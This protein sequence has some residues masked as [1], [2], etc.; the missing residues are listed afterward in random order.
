MPVLDGLAFLYKK[1]WVNC[2]QIDYNSQVNRSHQLGHSPGGYAPRGVFFLATIVLWG[3]KVSNG[4]VRI[5]QINRSTAAAISPMIIPKLINVSGQIRRPRI[6][7]MIRAPSWL[8]CDSPIIHHSQYSTRLVSSFERII[9]IFSKSSILI[10]FSASPPSNHPQHRNWLNCS[11]SQTTTVI[12]CNRPPELLVAVT[13]C[14]LPEVC[15]FF[16]PQNSGRVM[17]RFAIVSW[18]V[19]TSVVAVVSSRRSPG[20]TRRGCLAG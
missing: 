8:V 3:C 19:I 20:Q 12:I 5:Y 9:S 7:T 18:N 17:W 14:I 10:R 15:S 13:T 4:S 16:T 1:H 11:F 6:T 2:E